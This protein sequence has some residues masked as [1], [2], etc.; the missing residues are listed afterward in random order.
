MD[1][2]Q[3]VCPKSCYRCRY[4][5][6]SFQ[7]CHRQNSARSDSM[8]PRSVQ[9]RS[10]EE[11]L[12]ATHSVPACQTRCPSSQTWNERSG[13]CDIDGGIVDGVEI[14][15]RIKEEGSR[16]LQ[17]RVSHRI[18]R[19]DIRQHV[20]LLAQSTNSGQS[21]F[22]FTVQEESVCM[23]VSHMAIEQIVTSWQHTVLTV[24][25]DNQAA[26]R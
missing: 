11:I 16:I 7:L 15:E 8:N 4:S 24:L 5:S 17:P 23:M 9:I 25:M 20:H 26:L 18:C 13:Y 1:P 21:L 22:K 12:K 6:S 3:L 14:D 10:L 2:E 19:P